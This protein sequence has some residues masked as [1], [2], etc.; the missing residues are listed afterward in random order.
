MSKNKELLKNTII[1]FLGKISTQFLSFFLLPIYTHYL[2]TG[3]Y[4]TVDLILTYISLFVPVISI[5]QEMAT[6][7][8][9]IDSRENEKEKENVISVSFKN[10]LSRM[11]FFVIIYFIIFSFIK[12]KF[13]YY[14]IINISICIF[15]NLFLQIARGL[16]KNSNYS[17]A[18]FITGLITF[19][20]NILLICILKIGAKGILISMSVA[21]LI[22]IIYLVLS[23]KIYKYINL[24]IN[25]K[26]MKKEMLKYSIPLVI[27][28]ISWWFINVSDRTI[29]SI[30][31]GVTAN[32]IYAVS[33][34]FPSI[35]TSISNIFNLSWTESAAIHIND[36]DRNDF[37][38]NVSETILRLFS[39]LCMGIIAFLPFV[40]NIIIG[41]NYNDS[42]NYI[43]IFLVGTLSNCIVMV[44]SA[45]YI[46]KK[47]TNKV[48]ST[49]IMSAIINIAI[50]IIFIKKIGLYAA[51]ISTALAYFI[52][53]IYRH[54]DV[55]KYVKINYNYRI[56]IRI[57]IMFIINIILYYRN[58][59]YTNL[60]NIVL[61]IIFS[62]LLN[63]NTIIS[64]LLTIKNKLLRRKTINNKSIT[65]K[66]I[67]NE[68]PILDKDII[69]SNNY[70][71]IIN[72]KD[73]DINNNIEDVITINNNITE[74]EL[75]KLV[76]NNNSYIK[77][78][79]FNKEYDFDIV[80]FILNE[81]KI[82][83]F[84][85]NNKDYLR[86]NRY[87]IILSNSYNFM[88]YVIDNDINNIAYIN[89][90]NI[91]SYNLKKIIDYTFRKLYSLQQS[92][93]NITFDLNGI[94]KGSE[95]I[96]NNYFRE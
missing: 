11:I 36:D 54:F 14:I 88:R 79:D 1:I 93:N 55:K 6:F 89:T 75:S 57:T 4:G 58:N 26:K 65:N 80:R 69:N 62:I 56:I 52:M 71:D 90:S 25:N 87:P 50:N 39:C 72:N 35:V 22:C 13:K 86:N 2:S 43:P 7:R 70:N 73:I 30:F 33:T 45:I 38:T 59:V 84:K 53:M 28:S 21:N 29:I 9:L 18:S 85:F 60:L 32:G 68:I 19:I 63:K 8:Y 27:N 91:D 47:M 40:F 31:M 64:F 46:A 20:S 66:Y 23:L 82:Y 5:Q 37:F 24:Q 44:Y 15:S 42:Y 95:I 78:I 77:E 34:K 67:D 83:K 3:E 48:A 12:I 51:A 10:S 94:F 16:G 49:S 74:E 92:G 96:N 17:I 61:I 41:K 76:R 81:T